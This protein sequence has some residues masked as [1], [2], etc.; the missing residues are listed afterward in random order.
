MEGA[1]A[2]CPIHARKIGEVRIC[3]PP[4]FVT[5][6]ADAVVDSGA[7]ISTNPIT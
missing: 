1:Q 5:E 3:E 4:F 6:P 7:T 2:R